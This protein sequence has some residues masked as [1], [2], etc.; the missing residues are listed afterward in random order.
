MV[1]FGAMNNPSKP[2]ADEI[3][4]IGN[5]GFDFLDFTLEPT[6]AYFDNIEA[7]GGY[8]EVKRLLYRYGLD[9]VGHTA[10]FLPFS[11][12]FRSMRD[13]AVAE[14]AKAALFFS[15][16]KTRYMTVHLSRPTNNSF[17]EQTFDWTVESLKRLTDMVSINKIDIMV[18]NSHDSY[19]TTERISELLYKVPEL[20]FHLDV[21]HYFIHNNG[22]NGLE[23]TLER[24]KGKLVHVHMHDNDGSDD[25]HLP[26]GAGRIDWER[27]VRALKDIGYNDT[28][29]IELHSPDKDYFKMSRDKIKRLWMSS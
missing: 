14:A 1:K 15:M 27:V 12:P 5:N 2:L 3:D 17:S 20:R 26:I 28:I 18:E 21:A 7:L 6:Q 29:T 22:L 9:I 24:L 25:Q 16:L 13:V 23:E 11:S 19:W 8:G 4:W 10:Y